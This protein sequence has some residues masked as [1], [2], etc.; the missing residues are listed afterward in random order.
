MEIAMPDTLTGL[1]LFVVMLLPGFAY[2]VGKERSGTERRTSTF[3]ETVAIVAA[4]VTSELIVLV[5]FA[6]VRALWPSMTPDVGALIRQGGTYLRGGCG[7]PGHY[8]I[9]AIWGVCL[10]ALAVTL[11]FLAT[12][13][14]VRRRFVRLTGPYP[15]DSTVSAWWV[16]FERW[17]NSNNLAIELVCMLDDG[18]CVRGQYG[19]F[20]T[21]A[22]DSLERDVILQKPLYY[23]PPGDPAEEVPYS[24]AAVCCPASRIVEMFVNYTVPGQEVPILERV[25]VAGPQELPGPEPSA[26]PSE[27]SPSAE[28]QH[29][30][31]AQS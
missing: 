4:S 10:L 6:V 15:H 22:D 1:L 7:H 8:G 20:N 9:V 5:L 2:L 23:R 13:P 26:K 16:L 19:S 18:S 27:A 12:V 17:G 21:S 3:R 25:E 28:D 31:P 11:A 24:A 29:Q 30:V 14:N